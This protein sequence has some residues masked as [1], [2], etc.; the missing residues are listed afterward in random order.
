MDGGPH[1]LPDGVVA[2]EAAH[3]ALGQCAARVGVLVAGKQVYAE[4]SH[5]TAVE[6][7]EADGIRGSGVPARDLSRGNWP[8]QVGDSHTGVW[9]EGGFS[10]VTASC[11]LKPSVTGPGKPLPPRAGGILRG[12]GSSLRGTHPRMNAGNAADTS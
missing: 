1:L 8:V 4:A 5:D 2:E 7:P 12:G 9:L 6:C 3:L 11:G 10:L